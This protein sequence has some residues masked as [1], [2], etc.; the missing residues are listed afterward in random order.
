MVKERILIVEDEKDISELL[1]YN[2]QSEGFVPVKAF[3]GNEALEMV[4]KERPDL[5]LL[6]IMMPE[7]DGR[8]V[9]KALK[10]DEKTRHIPVVMLTAK[11]EESDVIVGLELGA[12]DYIVKPFSPKVLISRIK[13][14]LRRTKDRKPSSE[15]RRIGDFSIDLSKHKITYQDKSLQLT[16]IEFNI[17]E[18]LSRYPGTVFSRDQIMD[19]A[20]KEGKFIVDR[21]VDVH[22]R[23]LRKKLGKGSK[24][25][26]TVHGIGYRFKDIS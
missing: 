15:L 25:I 2:L 17:L 12:D 24:V 21:A 6:D 8:D 5:I 20:W 18:F 13:A 14:V 19:G 7:M 4:K 10:R 26:E 9:C 1:E 23:S 11:S 16:P 3:D 22:I